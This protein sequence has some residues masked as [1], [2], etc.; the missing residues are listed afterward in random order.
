MLF[1]MPGMEDRGG[2]ETDALV[3]F[4]DMYPS[5]CEACS[6]PIPDHCEGTSFLPLIEDPER[7]WKSAAFNLNPRGKNIMG[8]AVRTD[9]FRYVEWQDKKT[10]EVRARE[11]YDHKTD[12]HENINAAECGM[13][14]KGIDHII[15]V[16]AV[17]N[18]VLSTEEH[19]QGGIGH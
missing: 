12:A 2:L 7:V 11:L 4:V 6:I 5:L 18:Q 19:L 14:D 9:R 13:L 3:E 16:I 8:Y 10:G 17:A 1:Y 15:G